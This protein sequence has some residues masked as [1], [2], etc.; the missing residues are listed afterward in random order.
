MKMG[1]ICVRIKNHFRTNG[2]ALSLA[3]KE[4]LQATWKWPISHLEVDRET[5]SVLWR[6][7][8]WDCFGNDG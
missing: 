1:Y 7:A 3:L 4:R 8:P 6:I 5:G 2:F